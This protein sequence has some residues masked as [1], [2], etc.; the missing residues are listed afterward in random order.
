MNFL[1][2]SLSSPQDIYDM[3]KW[4]TV[5]ED[6]GKQSKIHEEKRKHMGHTLASSHMHL[7]QPIKMLLCL[8]SSTN[9]SASLS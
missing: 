5:Q 7:D 8:K 1:K 4:Q 6:L 2:L 3:Y 9:H